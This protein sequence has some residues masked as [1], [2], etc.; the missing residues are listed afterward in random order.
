MADI[1]TTIGYYIIPDDIMNE[2]ILGPKGYIDDFMLS[3]SI[4]KKIEIDYD[5]ET[6]A[7]HWNSD[8]DLNLVLNE[9]FEKVKKDYNYEY[10]KI[11]EL[12]P[13]LFTYK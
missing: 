4:L 2:K 10:H 12:L 11:K 5:H 7:Q 6:I 9:Y 13:S 3:V 8:F 1:L